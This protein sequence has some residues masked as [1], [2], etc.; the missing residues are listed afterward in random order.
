MTE[1]LSDYT[2]RTVLLGTM[3]LGIACGILGCVA[4]LRN[5]S[6]VG[7]ALSHAALPGICLGYLIFQ[8]VSTPVVMLGA[9][10]SG[11][12]ALGLAQ[13]VRR[14]TRLDDSAVLGTVLT[15]FFGAGVVLLTLLQRTPEASQAGLDK[16]LFGQVATMVQEQVV[17]VT[18]VSAVALTVF[19]LFFRPMKAL[20]FDPVFSEAAGMRTGTVSGVL[21]ALLL[22]AIVIG[23]NAV[24]VVLLSAMLVAPAVAARQWTDRL[25]PMVVLAGF[26]GGLC[27]LMGAVVSVRGEGLP[28][29][30][31]VVL[32]MTG[33]VVVS[34]LFGRARGVVWRRSRR[35]LMQ[36]SGGA[37]S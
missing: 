1:L 7:D 3:V 28:T 33:A 37:P 8:N 4:V 27:G 10:A 16:F 34:V 9:A 29:G 35:R 5:Q 30:P 14:T 11:G 18:V 15:T 36:A 21:S 17:T 22:V 31:V 23:L 19:V 13:L 25:A 24:G 26:L 32:T 20:A 2:L 6:L 12:L